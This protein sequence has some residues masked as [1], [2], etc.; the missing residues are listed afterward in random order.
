MPRTENEHAKD[1]HP[2]ISCRI[3]F[4]QKIRNQPLCIEEKERNMRQC[5]KRNH[6]D[7]P[8]IQFLFVCIGQRQIEPNAPQT[9][10]KDD[11][12]IFI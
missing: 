1:E 11:R 8:I 3:F 5:D 12:F 7:C 9:N 4:M 6:K 10:V 2:K